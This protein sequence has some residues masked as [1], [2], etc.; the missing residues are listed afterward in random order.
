MRV[1]RRQFIF[2]TSALLVAPLAVEAQPV[3]KV[4]KIGILSNGDPARDRT[5]RQGLRDLGYVEGRNLVI[6]ARY[7]KGN[8]EGLA[9]RAAELVK[10]KVDVLFAS[11]ST[12]VRAA[13]EATGTIPIVFAGHNDPVGTGDVRSL[14]RPGGNITGLTFMATD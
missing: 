6:E 9:A 3:G 11:S 10:L 5:F 4:Y 14:A 7:D 8:A 1:R 12:Y 2:A 13:K